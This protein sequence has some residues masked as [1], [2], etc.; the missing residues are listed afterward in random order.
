MCSRPH[1][2]LCRS[3]VLPPPVDRATAGMRLGSCSPLRSRP[4][5]LQGLALREALG[6]GDLARAS[7]GGVACRPQHRSCKAACWAGLQRI[8]CGLKVPGRAHRDATYA[9]PQAPQLGQA[10]LQQPTFELDAKEQQHRG[11]WPIAGSCASG[12]AHVHK[13]PPQGEAGWP[14]RLCAAAGWVA[15]AWHV[16]LLILVSLLGLPF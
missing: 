11:L 13:R 10:E 2:S 15:A 12:P 1:P 7:G 5:A 16:D 3:C 4:L 8:D 14:A 6:S 9:A